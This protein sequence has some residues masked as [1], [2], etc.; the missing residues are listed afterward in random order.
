MTG[1]HL[2]KV[3]N[4]NFYEVFCPQVCSDNHG[5]H[6]RKKRNSD[7]LS[8]IPSYHHSGGPCEASSQLSCCCQNIPLSRHSMVGIDILPEEILAHIFLFVGLN[9]LFQFEGASRGKL[10][11]R[12]WGELASRRLERVKTCLLDSVGAAAYY[13]GAALGEYQLGEE[14]I[15]RQKGTCTFLLSKNQEGCWEVEHTEGYVPFISRNDSHVPPRSSWSFR[16]GTTLV[17][18]PLVKVTL[19]ARSLLRCSSISFTSP[20]FESTFEATGGWSRGRPVFRNSEGLVAWVGHSAW[21]ITQESVME[22]G[23]RVRRKEVRRMTQRFLK[24][25]LIDK[26]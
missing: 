3:E 17:A 13:E 24:S 22:R 11:P 6:K 14:G 20:T 12:V 7:D 4:Y 1:L 25:N 21:I 5:L 23:E 16:R 18:D 19:S 15:Y 2:T 8:I 26:Y 9:Q 10:L